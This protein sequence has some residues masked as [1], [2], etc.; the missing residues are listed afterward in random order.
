MIRPVTTAVKLSLSS[1]SWSG[2]TLQGLLNWRRC[3][4]TKYLPPLWCVVGI[5]PKPLLPRQGE[6]Y[7]TVRH[8]FKFLLQIRW[9]SWRLSRMMR[10]R[11]SIAKPLLGAQYVA[12]AAL[13]P[14]HLAR[15]EIVMMKQVFQYNICSPKSFEIIRLCNDLFKH[16]FDALPPFE[17]C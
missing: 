16:E 3:S 17:Q 2:R 11:W 9:N 10:L 7:K 6:C 1:I 12:S 15:C 5:F 8:F 14:H 4:L 13:Q